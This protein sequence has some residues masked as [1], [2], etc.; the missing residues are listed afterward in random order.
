MINNCS[1]I[2]AACPQPEGRFAYFRLDA[3]LPKGMRLTAAL[4][5]AAR[6]RLWVNG[7]AVCSGPCAGDRHV[8][9]ADEVELTPYLRE[10]KNTF[11]AQVLC[12][13]HTEAIDPLDDNASLYRII[14]PDHRHRFAFSAKA[15][16]VELSTGKADWRVSVDEGISLHTDP[17]IQFLGDYTEEVDMRVTPSDWKITDCSAWPCAV[18]LE[19]MAQDDLRAR[20]GIVKRY[21]VRPRPIPMR[22]RSEEAFLRE[23]KTE[24]GILQ[25]DSITVP[26]ESVFEAVLDAGQVKVAEPAFRVEGGAGAC[27][28]ITYFEKFVK[29]GEIIPRNDWRNGK[30]VGIRDVVTL[31]GDAL[32]YEPF[33]V[34]TF[35][36]VSLRLTTKAAPAVLHAPT[37]CRTGYP[38]TRDSNV[39]SSVPWVDALWSM[40][41]ETLQNCMLDTYMDCPYYEQLQYIMD[42]RLQVLF[43]FAVSRDTALARKALE[44]FH[45]SQM[46]CGL[47][48]GKYPSAYPQ[49]I[50]TFSLHYIYMIWEYYWQTGDASVLKLY[51]ADCDR[52]LSYYEE[53]LS[54]KKLMG[55]PGFWP[56]VDWQPAWNG[57][58]GIPEALNHGEST[59]ITLMYAYALEAAARINEHSGRCAI[60]GE[61]RA[62]KDEI[63]KAVQACC[64]DDVRGMYREGPEFRQFTQHAQAWAVLCEIG[65]A[66]CLK[67]S[68]ADDVLKVTFSTAHEWFRALEK[69]GQYSYARRSLQPW[70]DL[71]ALDCKTCPETPVDTRSENHAW[72][73]LPMLELVRGI[74]G[75]KAEEPGWRTVSITPRMLDLP[76]LSAVVATPLGDITLDYT[77][78]TYE[79]TL[80]EGMEGTFLHPDGREIPIGGGRHI[81]RLTT[82]EDK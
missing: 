28:E 26:A 33:Y 8:W 67:N 27:L 72:S 34:R 49:V 41:V 60:A 22:F 15:G 31:N 70:I 80:P 73:A 12:L 59:I 17:L 16:D 61:Y 5:A 81:I 48:P 1:W 54:E 36:F 45:R 24:T 11:A 18:T 77:K 35:R 68:M 13:D 64:W 42:T 30:I 14:A 37:F 50:S 21:I 46:P 78:S 43:N 39:H 25:A 69:T 38:L 63:C 40:C 47:L 6:Y 53:H 62:L 9:Y 20:V 82:Q 58:M 76:D 44:D 74:A 7:Q 32:C 75:V 79:V 57:I 52:I 65:D 4:T 71:I 19:S 56:F 2:G 51:R 29:E 66:D 10:G 55:H 23:V 3:N